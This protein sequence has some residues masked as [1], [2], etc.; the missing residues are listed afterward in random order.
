MDSGPAPHRHAATGVS[1]TAFNFT[2]QRPQKL[3]LGT[4]SEPQ[5]RQFGMARPP[6]VQNSVRG[7]A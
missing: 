1:A 3:A 5:E 6:R 4:V 2:P 7:R